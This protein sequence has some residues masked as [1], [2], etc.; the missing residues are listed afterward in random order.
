VNA[1][2]QPAVAAPEYVD[3]YCATGTSPGR[4]GR[5]AVSIPTTYGAELTTRVAFESR[6]SAH[7]APV[8]VLGGISAGRHLLP[9]AEAP[10]AG[11]WPGIVEVGGVLD[12]NRNQLIGIDFVGGPGGEV[13][14]DHPISTFDQAQALAAVLDGLGI[15]RVTLVGSSYG[16]M[17]A[18]AFAALFPTRTERTV[19][20]CAAH[21]SHPMATALRSIQRE[22]VRF[23]DEVGRPSVGLSLARSLA[24]TTYRST[25]EFDARFDGAPVVE[26][27]V[28]R[29][30]VESYLS[31]RGQQ[32]AQTF[33]PAA[34]L[35]LSESLD[36]HTVNPAEIVAATTVVSFDTDTLVPPWLVEELAAEAPGVVDHIELRSDFGHDAFLKE[37]ESVSGVLRETLGHGE[38]VC[39]RY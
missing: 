3:A 18:L 21:R 22:T 26:N 19:V 8:V 30:P 6:G 36:L 29:F 24:M 35:A 33:D 12:P 9:T 5:I 4:T 11:W 39:A 31:A 37:V 28:A 25:V 23:A 27:G 13:G 34:F 7:A 10:E 32:F 2:T 14:F 1:S 15:E 20:F 17:V 16:G 38:R